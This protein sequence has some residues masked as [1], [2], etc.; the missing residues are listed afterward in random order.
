MSISATANRI[1]YATAAMV[2]TFPFPYPFF[3]AS[4]LKV[5]LVNTTTFAETLLVLGVDYT[6]SLVPDVNSDA[7]M[8][9]VVTT[10]TNPAGFNLVI[11]RNPSPVQGTQL[12]D[13]GPIPASALNDGLDKLTLM[14]QRCLDLA[15][16][17]LVLD[18]GFVGAFNPALPLQMQA[19]TLIGINAGATALQLYPAAVGG[20]ST[21]ILLPTRSIVFGQSPYTVV[22]ATDYDLIVDA[23]GGAVQINAPAA[24][25]N[26]G[27]E[28]RVKRAPSDVSGNPIT[29]ASAAGIDGSA[30]FLGGT[31]VGPWAPGESNAFK[32]NSTGT[33]F[34]VY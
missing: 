13:N 33:A 31:G 32:A 20:G 12:I 18:D 14:L 3:S 6:V 30:T 15:N 7:D 26:Q 9:S 24:A 23:S 25:G 34:N 22:P 29:V 28:F 17:G 16:R 11:I 5:L 8:G 27:Y 1:S 4:D 10:V 19:G 21:G 2:N